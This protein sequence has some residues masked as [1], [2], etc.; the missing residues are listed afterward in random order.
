VIAIIDREKLKQPTATLVQKVSK[1]RIPHPP[2]MWQFISAVEI[3][4]HNP[5]IQHQRQN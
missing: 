4:V 1:T 5:Q 2:F 3:V